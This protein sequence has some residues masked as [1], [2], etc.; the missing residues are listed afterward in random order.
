MLERPFAGIL[1]TLLFIGML[2]LA[3]NI[4][5]VEASGTVYIRA[6]GSVDP[7][8][9]HIS[10]VDNITYTF[11][12]NI[13]DSIVVERSNIIINGDGYTVQGSGGGYGFNL[14]SIINVTIQNTNI[15]K[16][17]D[18]IRLSS[19]SNNS[20]VGNNVTANNEN[21]IGLRHSSNNSVSGNTITNNGYG[22]RL[23]S[24]SN[25]NSI[26]HNNFIDNAQ[27]VGIYQ[28]YANVWDDGYP[29][30]GN[31]WSDYRERYPDAIE[32]D[33]SGIWDTPY[34]INEN[35]RDNYPLMEPWAPVTLKV[36]GPWF[37]TEMDKF[38]PV[39]ETFKIQTGINVEYNRM[40]P[41]DLVNLLPEEFEAGRTPGDII[42]VWPWFIREIG[43]EGHALDVTDLIDEANFRPGVLD[44]V[45]VDDTL[46][47]ASYTGKVEPGFWYRKSFF[48]AHG[49]SEPTTWSE[50]MALLDNIAAIVPTGVPI[51]SGD[52]VGW[53]LSDITEHF[54]IT[55]GGPQLQK[56]LIAGTVDWNST[57]VKTTVFEEK[58]VPLLTARYLSEPIEW[59][60]AL[61]LW[62]GGDYGL[63]FMGS[64][65]TAMVDD[66]EDLGVFSLPGAEGLV[67]CADYFFIP[68]CT[69][70]TEEAKQLFQFLASAE[71]QEVQ[72][73]QGGHI[74]TNI[75]VS[76][77]AYPSVDRRVA[78]LMEGM[79]VLPDLD[80]TIG[81]VFQIT[82][83]DQL[84]LLWVDPTKLD[85]VLDALQAVAPR[86]PTP[87]VVTATVDI[88][89]DTLN[90]KSNGKWITAYIELPEG[91]D[92]TDINVTTILL[93]DTI[94][95]ELRPVAIGDYDEDGIPDL[96]AKFHRA[97]VIS[98][99]LA[100]VNMTELIEE[101]FMTVTL[102]ITGCLNDGTPFQ[103]SDT[104]KI[105]LYTPRE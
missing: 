83:W 12:G 4:Q 2:T 51:A 5:P 67:F 7:S 78:E 60:T 77:D 22:I 75:H 43:P 66:P 99:I 35:N 95:A 34:K 11:T 44:Q 9:A 98:Y 71:A 3:F 16:F 81:G 65:I 28:S 72:V 84:K 61:D 56:D 97:E 68:T 103:G 15:K 105:I 42:F 69:D 79:T 49:L 90:L 17:Y 23:Y 48:N 39:L 20:I 25:Y 74:A 82:F 18:G 36:I 87:P 76:L 54:I 37:G 57:E 64:W 88:D 86:P 40:S 50:F 21:G 92:A 100:N 29:S 31:Y 14:T 13:Y 19:S 89:P 30:G 104:T 102:T 45:K 52:G 73:A 94:H 80:D 47:G 63:Y 26:F 32:L 85:A 70:Y 96:I 27:Q 58:L 93:N 62:W 101:R 53:P 91:Y 10:S 59:T 41:L 1:L 46:Y 8:T 33:G 6:D 38:L 55:Y 24:S